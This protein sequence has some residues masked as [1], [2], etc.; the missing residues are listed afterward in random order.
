[1]NLESL[2]HNSELVVDPNYEMTK[3]TVIKKEE[4]VLVLIYAVEVL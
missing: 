4:S 1:V 3:L 2:R